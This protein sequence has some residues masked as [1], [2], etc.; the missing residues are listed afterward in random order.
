MQ[1]G[2]QPGWDRRHCVPIYYPSSRDRTLEVNRVPTWLRVVA[3]HLTSL[4]VANARP[5]HE[6]AMQKVPGW[7]SAAITGGVFMALILLELRRPLR[8]AKSE[9]KL[10]RNLR[11]MAVAG[12]SAVAVMLT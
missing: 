9:P 3:A 12:T 1:S 5:D 2:Q 10:R 7:L 4:R 11:N 6:L 8:K